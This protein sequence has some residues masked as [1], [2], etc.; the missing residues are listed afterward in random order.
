MPLPEKLQ[1][2]QVAVNNRLPYFSAALW[3]VKVIETERMVCPTTGKPTMGADDKWRIYYHPEILSR[4]D[5]PVLGGVVAHELV[6]LLLRHSQRGQAYGDDLDRQVWN[7]AVD[8]EANMMLREAGVTLPDCACFPESF[9]LDGSRARLAEEWYEMLMQ[10]GGGQGATSKVQVDV[11]SGQDGAEE[12]EVPG[13]GEDEGQDGQGRPVGGVGE[14]EAELIRRAVAESVKQQGLVPAGLDRWAE[15]VLAPVVNWRKVLKS[16]VRR[17]VQIAAGAQD[18]SYR[19]PS[20][21][22][23]KGIVLPSAIG[24][25]P[26]VGVVVDTSGSMGQE[27]LAEALAEVKGVLKT[28]GPIELVSVDAAVHGGKQRVAKVGQVQ[29]GGG[30]GTD[31]RVGIE[32]L[33]GQADVVIVLTDGYTPWPEHKPQGMRV[34]VGLVGAGASDSAPGWATVIRI[35]EEGGE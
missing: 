9:G 6:H 12:A 16:A 21:R 11:C 29:L 23:P 32:E 28:V 34:V 10:Q 31:M 7:F 2:G 35:R 24:Y 3:S 27:D 18:Y 33:E 4:F 22:S 14:F 8:I 19:K 15:N 5:G 20:R 1:A 30:G 26:K 25:N 13:A 17:Q